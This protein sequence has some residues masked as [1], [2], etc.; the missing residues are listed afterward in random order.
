M[1]ARSG[2][3]LPVLGFAAAM[4]AG[5]ATPGAFE[6]VSG[7]GANP[8]CMAPWQQ[9]TAFLKYPRKQGPF[10]IAL[11]N[12][13]SANDW[14]KQMM[15]TARAYVAQPEIAAQIRE[16]KAV[17]TGEDVNAQVAA[18]NG[19]ID[20]GYDAI[21]VDAENPN[22]FG[23]VIARARQAGIVLVAFDNTLDTRDAINVDVDQKGIGRL[24]AE[25]LIQNLPEGGTLL[26]VRGVEG[27]SVDSDRHEGAR[28]TLAASG[29]T[30]KVIEARGKWN[31]AVAKQATA[32]AIA[33]HGP[34]DGIISQ[35]GDAGVIA[36]LME[37]KHPF[38]PMAGETENGFRKL[39][40]AYAKD[41]LKCSSAGTGPAQVA[42]AIKVALTALE[43][44]VVAQAIKL[45]TTAVQDPDIQAGRDY[46]PDQADGF[47]VG[48]AF[49]SCGIALSV[50]EILQQPDESP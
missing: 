38:V 46:Y 33:A 44:Q 30:W 4:M 36:A 5:A 15:K 43:G 11:S 25:W 24:S 40:A 10:R 1:R 39:C 27:T 7:P 29:K 9:D 18:I 8:D 49:P 35:A 41:G 3:L 2:K 23:P 19:F 32:E 12:G 22:A 14:R 42:V 16:F 26:E 6:V 50:T 17:S 20:A 28:E 47:F 21:V 34:F 37:A 48:N 13:Y 31:D 45:P